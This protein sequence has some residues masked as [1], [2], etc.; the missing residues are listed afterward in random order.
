M[1]NRK[2]NLILFGLFI[3]VLLVLPWFPISEI[4]SNEDFHWLL[5]PFAHEDSLCEGYKNKY[6]IDKDARPFQKTQQNFGRKTLILVDAWGVPLESS[7]LE[8]DFSFFEKLP[9]E[10]VI[11]KRLANRNVQ[12]E[13]DELR[14]D[15]SNALFLFGGDSLEYG[16]KKYIPELGFNEVLFCQMCGDSVM[17]EKLDSAITESEKLLLDSS[18]VSSRMFAWTTQTSRDGNRENLH[19]T[20]AGIAELARKHPKMQFVIQGTH[21]P[22]LGSPETRRM[23]HAHWVPVVLINMPPNALK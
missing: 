1:M 7:T 16:R 6:K 12:A 5:R 15:F 11:R 17:L 18:A 21:R 19:K 23:Y 13:F 10:F 9:H 2:V 4:V 22:I 3:A 14:N 8:E 20:L